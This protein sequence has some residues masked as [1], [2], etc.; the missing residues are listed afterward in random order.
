MKVE[1]TD[2]T[3]NKLYERKEIK[4]D[5]SFVGPTPKKA[6]IK[7]ELAGKVGA[8]PELCIIRKIKNEF[9]KQEVAVLMHSYESAETLKKNE[10]DFVLVREGLAQKKEKKKKVKKTAA[11]AKKK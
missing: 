6:E 9:G 1:I 3:E 10:P 11:P 8:N 5:V 7:T 4:A 2:T